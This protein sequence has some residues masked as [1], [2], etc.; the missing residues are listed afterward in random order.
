MVFTG[1]YKLISVKEFARSVGVDQRSAR[2][3]VSSGQIPSV[4]MG[5][6]DLISES[7]I[8]QIHSSQFNPRELGA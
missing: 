6:R 7:V 4:R 5:R 1:E 3:A 2:N 8:E